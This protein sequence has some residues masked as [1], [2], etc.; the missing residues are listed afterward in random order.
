M[1]AI[2]VLVAVTALLCLAL[3]VA[4]LHYGRK[5]IK[6][7]RAA[8]FA[9]FVSG[10]AFFVACIVTMLLCVPPAAPLVCYIVACLVL[11]LSTFTGFMGVGYKA[12]L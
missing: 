4:G 3:A 5:V 11:A 1:T 7:Q 6:A 10:S 12:S 8:E 9:I 2:D